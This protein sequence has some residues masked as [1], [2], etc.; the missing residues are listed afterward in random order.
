MLVQVSK[1]SVH[2]GL[3]DIFE[4]LDF[5]IN[6]NE[7]I[8]IVGRNGCGKTTLLK[9]I[10]GLEELS[11]GKIFYSGN[12]KIGY[13]SQSHFESLENSVEDELLQSFKELIALEKIIDESNKL[14]LTDYSETNIIKH[15]ELLEKFDALGGYSYKNELK[16]VFYGFGFKEEDLG[17]KLSTFSGGQQT[18]IYFAKMLLEKPDLL[19][20][21]EPTNHLDLKTIEWLENYLIKYKRAM[22]LVSHDRMF[23]NKIVNTIYDFEYGKLVKYAGNYDQFVESKKNRLE[24]NIEAYN[25]QQKEIKQLEAQIEKFRYKASKASFAQSKIKYLDRMDKIEKLPEADI[26]SFKANFK[27]KIRGGNNV[28]ALDNLSFGYDKPLA[29][30]NLNIMRN[31]R[32]CIMGDNGTGKSTLLKTIV[33]LIKPLSGY[34]LLGHQIEIGYFDQQLLNFSGNK[35]VIEEIWDEYPDLEHTQIRTILG[36]FLFRTEEVFKDIKVLSGGEKVRLAFVKLML[37][38][39][40]FL[41][42][43]EPTNHLDI[44]GKEALEASLKNY[45]GTIIF[46]SHDRYFI[47]E[48]ANKV[49][50]IEDGKTKLY[51][52]G[53]S[54]YLDKPKVSKEAKESI[55]EVKAKIKPK[56]KYNLKKI[57][58]EIVRLED[59]L[60]EKRSLRFEEEYYQDSHKM[61]ILND[62]IDDLHNLIHAEMQKWELAMEEEEEFSK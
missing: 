22:I 12:L 8:A 60:E 29:S 25:R 48:I 21:D 54:E 38:G 6:E 57:E 16:A 3:N 37:K 14:L 5:T 41:V 31:D 33:D 17:R 35:T 47:K 52:Y 61:N 19:L 50:L 15:S 53:Y 32:I 43:D 18:K 23:I 42:L 58:A 49:L 56:Q 51:E 45:D 4:Q 24:K 30:V 20:L 62:E 26:K 59:L 36:S 46:V 34:K 28:L 13:L 40:N 7:K 55:N 11:S 10:A 2:Y 27:S 1:G 44:P 39:A 9:V